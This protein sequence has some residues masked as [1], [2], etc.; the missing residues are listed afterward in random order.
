[1]KRKYSYIE[2]KAPPS[3]YAIAAAL[4]GEPGALGRV[5]FGTLQRS[6]FI[7]P[8]LLLAGLR[9]EPLVRTALLASTSITYC[10]FGLYALRR[11]GYIKSWSK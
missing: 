9:G 2:P 8:G 11:G 5:F 6:V 10:F 1:M 4:E 3:S 7:V